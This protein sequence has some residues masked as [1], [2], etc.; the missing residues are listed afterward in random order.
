M[1]PPKSQL[2]CV[3]VDF[4]SAFHNILFYVCNRSI[5][6]MSIHDEIELSAYRKILF[7]VA[8]NLSGLKVSITP[9]MRGTRNVECESSILN[10]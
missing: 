2:C 7:C 9:T 10:S 3:L 1:F 4:H 6:L 5:N 8:H